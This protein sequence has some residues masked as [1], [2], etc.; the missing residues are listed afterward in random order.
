[1]TYNCPAIVPT[2]PPYACP[3]TPPSTTIA[4]EGPTTPDTT[5]EQPSTAEPT[6]EEPMIPEAITKE[7]TTPEE[8]T[9]TTKSAKTTTE[10]PTATEPDPNTNNFVLI[11]SI[12]STKVTSDFPTTNRDAP[13]NSI[14]DEISNNNVGTQTSVVAAVVLAIF[15]VIIAVILL[16]LTIVTFVLLYNKSFNVTQIYRQCGITHGIPNLI[17]HGMDSH[18]GIGRNSETDQ[19]E[20]FG[21]ESGDHEM[22]TYTAENVYSYPIVDPDKSIEAKRNDAYSAS[23]VTKKNEAYKPAS[24]TRSTCSDDYDYI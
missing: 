8:T 22:A 19:N 9:S 14:P 21:G 2:P 6:T 15:V 11:D 7:Q 1:M 4:T 13:T 16:S 12:L 3:T 17:M 5:A 20:A 18:I 24:A 10:E 23:I